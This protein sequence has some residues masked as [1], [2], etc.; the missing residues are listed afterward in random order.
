M[1]TSKFISI[2]LAAAGFAGAFTSCSKNTDIKHGKGDAV[3]G[4]AQASYTFKESAGIAKIPVEIIGSPETYPLTFDITCEKLNSDKE[5][6]E[7][8]VFTQ[9]KNFKDNGSV[10]ADSTK[11][12]VIVE[13][14]VIDDADINED[15]TYTITITNV[16]GAKL[17]EQS[18]TTVVIKD[19]DNNPYEKLWGKWT[20]TGTKSNGDPYSSPVTICGG[21]TD[22]EVEANA[23]KVLVAHGFAGYQWSDGTPHFNIAY[24]GDSETLSIMVGYNMTN[25][26]DVDW[27][28]GGSQYV[29]AY[30]YNPASKTISDKIQIPGKWNKDMTEMTF[31]SSLGLIAMIFSDGTSTGYNWSSCCAIKLTR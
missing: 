21:F 2:L 25:P 1:K 26:G 3:I 22:E 18:S 28:L 15:R 20:M 5:V 4:F 16:K 14:K 11:V 8:M 24:D 31:D 12:P 6:S 9:T 17:A 23:D 13:F 27:G 30:S 19:N 29:V 7:I 10:L